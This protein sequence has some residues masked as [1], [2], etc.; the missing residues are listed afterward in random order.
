[1]KSIYWQQIT[2]R[3]DFCDKLFEPHMDDVLRGNG[4]FCSRKCAF[5]Y[6]LSCKKRP[7]K[8]SIICST[9]TKP[10]LRIKTYLKYSEIYF[11][12]RK[13]K[14]QAHRTEEG[15]GNKLQYE[16]GMWS[17]RRKAV[18][19]YGPVCMRCSYDKYEKMLDVH[20]RD[21]NRA[22]NK[23]ENLEVLCVWCH[24]LESRG[25]PAHPWSGKLEEEVGFEP[26]VPVISSTLQFSRLMS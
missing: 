25:I 8:V 14:D 6:G 7:E 23:I 21:C 15:P 17:Y 20:H 22:N 19:H 26:T 12:T 4:R 24:L 5:G 16:E 10:F 11:C 2:R 1:M 9:C 18:K 13:C 3:C